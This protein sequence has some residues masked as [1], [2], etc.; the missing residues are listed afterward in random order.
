[1]QNKYDKAT[2]YSIDKEQQLEWSQFVSKE[3]K[4]YANY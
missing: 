2:E 1:M 3:L 4:K